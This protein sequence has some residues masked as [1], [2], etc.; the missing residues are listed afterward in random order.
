[1]A[2][3]AKC[4]NQL[5]DG[6]KFCPKCGTPVKTTKPKT[7][8]SENSLRYSVELISSGPWILQ[9]TKILMD[10]LGIEM[11]E[12]KDIIN[13]TP[14]VL[15]TDISLSRAEEIAQILQNVGAEI[16]IKQS[17]KTY[18][19]EKSFQNVVKQSHKPIID[20]QPFQYGNS[21]SSDNFFTLLM[22]I[23]MVIGTIFVILYLYN[24]FQILVSLK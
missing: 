17:N 20:E 3:C 5:S 1:M 16:E 9:T 23:L 13:S 6:A 14:S 24:Y 11:R 4:G 2:Y 22:K 12:A 21:Y 7:D 19:V 18:I 15:V 10:L 8:S